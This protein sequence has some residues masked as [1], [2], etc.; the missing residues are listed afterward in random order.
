MQNVD[1]MVGESELIDGVW[2]GTE[3]FLQ[4]VYLSRVVETS[5]IYLY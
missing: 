5:Q 1:T 2:Q 4:L 3:C